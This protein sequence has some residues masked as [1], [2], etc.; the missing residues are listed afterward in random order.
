MDLIDNG[1]RH[2]WETVALATK[3]SPN[4]PSAFE[5]KDFVNGT[6]KEVVEAGALTRLERP[7][8]DCGQPHRCGSETT[9]G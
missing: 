4:A 1:Y 6:I 5:H 9:F 7:T 3:E 2:L 8:P